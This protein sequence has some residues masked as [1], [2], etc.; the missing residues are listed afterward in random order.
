MAAA[1]RRSNTIMRAVKLASGTLCLTL[2]VRVLHQQVVGS[3][4]WPAADSTVPRFP[5]RSGGAQLD[6]ATHAGAF[7]D[8]VGRRSAIFG[9][10]NRSFEA[11]VYPLKI[12]DDFSLSFRLEGYPLAEE[13]GG[14]AGLIG[15]PSALDVSLMPYQ[16][17]PRDVP[18]RFIIDLTADTLKD[19][20]IPIVIAG[21]VE[22]RAAAKAAYDRVLGS[23][24]MLYDRTATHYAELDRDTIAVETPDERLN[25]AF[26]WAKV[27]IDKGLATNPLLGTG[28]VAGFRS[29]G[30]SER[31]GYAWFFG[32]DALWTTFAT[33]A[34]GDFATT[35]SA[36]EF[37][38]TYQRQD[39][40]IPHEVSQSASIVPWFDQYP[41]AWA[42]ADATPLYVIAHHDY[43]RAS[44]DRDFLQRAW[45]SI[46]RAYRFSAATDADGNG[47]V[48]NTNVGHGW[49]EGGALY[50][51]HEE[52]YMQ[53]LWVAASRGIAELAGVMNDSALAS[54]AAAAAERTRA[55]MEAIYWRAD[56]S[57]YA[58]ATAVPRS[59]PAIAEPGPNR[60]A[61][62]MRLDALRPARLIDEDTVLPA[63]PL[64]FGA[65]QDDR[66]Q[67]ELDHLGSGAIATGW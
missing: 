29:S 9:Y 38:R 20:R 61:R 43:W 35:R 4:P 40:K 31:P 13:S 39:G 22:G 56:R 45:P 30:E 58:F 63:V 47:L 37:L 15:C 64:W 23:V 36:L 53:G 60:R 65:V 28:L 50:P 62:Q 33:S 10:E 24:Q 17:E 1:A 48:E 67:A 42:S 11:W 21:S 19:R 18:N 49:V 51:A 57:F 8:V 44:G 14:Y 6:R 3:S 59:S 16:E 32:R 54:A 52:M 27:G 5:L 25:T 66:A 7:F 41:Y 2:A 12:L 55:A 26:Q 46:V 34:A